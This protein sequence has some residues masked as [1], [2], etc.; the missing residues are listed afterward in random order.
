M[1]LFNKNKLDS[2]IH[3]YK[4]LIKCKLVQGLL[5]NMTHD[6]HFSISQTCQVTTFTCKYGHRKWH[7][8]QLTGND[9][10]QHIDTKPN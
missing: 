1:D 3:R 4:R 8:Q 10:Q 2:L 7:A 9:N 6:D 5:Y